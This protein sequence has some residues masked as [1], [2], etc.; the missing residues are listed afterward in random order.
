MKM[1][2]SP[3]ESL[4]ERCHEGGPPDHELCDRIA[5]CQAYFDEDPHEKI[6]WWTALRKAAQAPALVGGQ[7]FWPLIE[8]SLRENPSESRPTPSPPTAQEPKPLPTAAEQEARP[9]HG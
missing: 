1:H 9:R 2:M 3:A 4:I 6:L 8:S 5:R 7:G